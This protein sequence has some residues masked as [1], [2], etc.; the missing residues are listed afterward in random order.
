V[1][2]TPNHIVLITGTTRGLGKSIAEHFL[3]TGSLVIGCARTKATLTHPQ[4]VHHIVDLG[5]SN[6]KMNAFALMPIDSMQNMLSINVQGTFHFCQKSIGLL[7][8]SQHPRIIN[9][10]SVAVPLRIEG[11]AVYAASKSAI[12]TLTRILAKELGNFHITCN[13]I[14]PSP[15]A[16]D[17]I[18]NVPQKKIGRLIQQQAVKKMATAADIIHL[19]DFLV[20]PESDMITGQVIYLG[21]IS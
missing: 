4:Y 2:Q 3:E 21:G 12:E 7:R 10:S 6:A 16:T 19:I 9:M 8:K 11:E 15:I 13:A 17:L 14:G 18:R 1:N 20:H 5:D